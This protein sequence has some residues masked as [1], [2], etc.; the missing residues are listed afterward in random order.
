ME[1]PPTDEEFSLFPAAAAAAEVDRTNQQRRP[2]C[3][4]LKSDALAREEAKPHAARCSS[5][6]SN[7]TLSL[8]SSFR[9]GFHSALPFCGSGRE[10]REK[11]KLSFLE[12]IL[13]LLLPKQSSMR[14]K[15]RAAQLKRLLLNNRC[16]SVNCPQLLL[17]PQWSQVVFRVGTHLQCD[18][19]TFR[20]TAEIVLGLVAQ[21]T[22][23][24]PRVLAAAGGSTASSS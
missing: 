22:T 10:R 9:L 3:P 1:L 16:A 6:G 18:H 19:L 14:G 5:S 23:T 7:Q 4:G 15:P 11:E 21:G 24:R 8:S 13:L 20:R 17:L 12:S 2:G